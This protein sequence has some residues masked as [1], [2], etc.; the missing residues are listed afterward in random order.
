MRA[1]TSE[2]TIMVEDDVRT[3]SLGGLSLAIFVVSI[4]CLALSLISVGLRTHIRIFD[5]V[6]GLDDGLILAGVVSLASN[7]FSSLRR[8]RD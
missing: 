8:R 7:Y 2:S 1:R 6:F 4:V 5:N 3:V